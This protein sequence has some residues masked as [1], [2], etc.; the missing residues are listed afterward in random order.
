MASLQGLPVELLLMAIEYEEE[1]LEQLR[2]LAAIRAQGALRVYIQRLTINVNSL[3]DLVVYGFSSESPGGNMSSHHPD[4]TTIA[5][6][7]HGA[8]TASCKQVL[9]MALAGLSDLVSIRLRGPASVMNR[10]PA[11]IVREMER[12]WKIAAGVVLSTVLSKAARLIKLIVDDEPG[13]LH[14]RPSALDTAALDSSKWW[15]SPQ[16]LHLYLANVPDQ[17]SYPFHARMAATIFK[18]LPRLTDLYFALN[19]AFCP[20]LSQ[21]MSLDP[22]FAQPS[23]ALP[24]LTLRCLHLAY[25]ITDSKTLTK[26]FNSTALSLRSFTLSRSI[27]SSLVDFSDLI[28]RLEQLPALEECVFHRLN[29]GVMELHFDKLNSMRPYSVVFVSDTVP[30][31]D[32]WLYVFTSH[33]KQEFSIQAAGWDSVGYWLEKTR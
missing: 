33:T 27:F 21:S 22:H 15:S 5:L 28:T 6:A 8:V 25:L 32:E 9:G 3:Y 13:V 18:K 2:L 12:R 16:G 17:V 26:F 14:M 23:D 29:V 11:E 19:I 1:T 10:V 31:P 20:S 7:A 30:N 4:Y 24:P